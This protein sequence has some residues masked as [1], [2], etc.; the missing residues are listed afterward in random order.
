[1]KANGLG[2]R[3]GGRKGGMGEAGKGEKGEEFRV[4][5]PNEKKNETVWTKGACCTIQCE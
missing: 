2:G 3:K 1:M 5:F 4:F